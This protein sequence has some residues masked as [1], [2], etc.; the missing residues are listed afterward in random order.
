MAKKKQ[1]VRKKHIPERTC[2]ACRTK[3]SKRD[4]VRVVNVPSEG[5]IV[6]E[7]GK[8][9]GR[10]AYLCRQ[11]ACWSQALKRGMLTRA[12]RTALSPEEITILQTFASSL[13]A[14]SGSVSDL[15]NSNEED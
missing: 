7:T 12:L 14:S 9:N 6:D 8:K 15:N 4:L 1:L 3:R 13:V 10:G 11:Y 2:I 5:V